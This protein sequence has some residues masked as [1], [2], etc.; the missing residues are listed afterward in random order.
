MTIVKPSGLDI[1]GL[2]SSNDLYPLKLQNSRFTN[3]MSDRK[4]I[5]FDISFQYNQTESSLGWINKTVLSFDGL[6]VENVF[7]YRDGGIFMV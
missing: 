1:L 5:L 2:D 7:S 3:V 4:S 6:K